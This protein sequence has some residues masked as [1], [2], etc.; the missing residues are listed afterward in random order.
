MKHYIYLWDSKTY[1]MRKFLVLSIMLTGLVFSGHAIKVDRAVFPNKIKEGGEI[2]VSLTV[3]K[4]GIEGFARLIETV[5]EGF[6]AEELNSATGNFIFENGKIR[7]IWLTMPDGDFYRAEYKLI[8]I[9]KNTGSIK[10]DGKFHYVKDDKRLEISLPSFNVV[11]KKTVAP[12]EIIRLEKPVE[13]IEPIVDTTS[14]IAVEKV[15]PKVEVVAV[16]KVEPKVEV[17]AVEKVEP[18]VEVVTVEKVEPKVE[19]VTV[20]KVEPKVEQPVDANSGL[21]FKVQLGAYSSEKP[22]SVFGNLPDIHFIKVGKIFKYYSGKFTNEAGARAVIPE[23]K[24]QGFKGAFLV[25]FK[26]GKRI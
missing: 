18:K 10:L 24:A 6:K 25:R 5:P 2:I 1:M 9:G 22:S 13:V 8:H 21:F 17:V 11:V 7:I 4:E 15:E 20:E 3:K 26:D 19:V 14:E 23:A 16:E 12:K